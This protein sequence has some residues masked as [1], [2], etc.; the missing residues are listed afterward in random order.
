MSAGTAASIQN[1]RV[2]MKKE[3]IFGVQPLPTAS[4]GT[5]VGATTNAAG[6]AVG[7][8][9]ITLASDGTGTILT[10]D[11]ITIA[12]DTNYY[13]VDNGDSDVSNGGTIVLKTGLKKAIAASAKAI[14]IATVDRQGAI[15][16]VFA[17]GGA[18]FTNKQGIIESNEIKP[19]RMTANFDRETRKFTSDIKG[20]LQ[21][22]MYDHLLASTLGRDFADNLISENPI[23]ADD[24]TS[25]ASVTNIDMNKDITALH[26][27]VGD[28]IL[29]ISTTSTANA[30]IVNKKFVVQ[31]FTAATGLLT[32]RPHSDNYATAKIIADTAK[33]IRIKNLTN[34]ILEYAGN[35]NFIEMPAAFVSATVD[36]TDY[37]TV[38]DI[39]IASGTG[40]A[41]NRN[42]Q[43]IITE[44]AGVS[45]RS[46]FG[47]FINNSV[48]LV[49]NGTTS[50]GGATESIVLTRN[51]L[52]RTDATATN[53]LAI[54]VS[55]STYKITSTANSLVADG[56][57]VGT[58]F[59]CFGAGFLTAA[60]KGR[61]FKV[62]AMAAN[63]SNLTFIPMDNG[64]APVAETGIDGDPTGYIQ[65]YGGTTYIPQEN[66]T[67][68]SWS[69]EEFYSD[70]TQ[71]VLNYGQKVAGF[72]ITTA[73]NGIP[74][75]SFTLMGKGANNPSA[76]EFY[77]SATFPLT[78]TSLSTIYSK[79]FYSGV[80]IGCITKFD[81]NVVNGI[82]MSERC[83]GSDTAQHSFDGKVKVSGTVGLLFTNNEAKLLYLNKEEQSL[84]L[85]LGE[86]AEPT[87]DFL[88]FTMPRV[89]FTEADNANNMTGCEITMPFTAFENPNGNDGAETP[90]IMSAL[91]I[92]SSKA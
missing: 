12:G 28:T 6:Y 46:I 80:Q 77:T 33:G 66:H 84:D 9:T 3:R 34:N 57:K 22:G 56:F 15:E 32:L 26:L 60:N 11:T 91:R 81:L 16:V 76:S 40:V 31:A 55:G 70:I 62:I 36:W 10:G 67:T 88:S 38:G 30:G 78:S 71:S 58:V 7:T 24:I 21:A 25:N 85:Y 63:G 39:V 54:T 20:D 43:F 68:D 65:Q 72:S 29:V 82:T 27:A 74:Q 41:G 83:Y 86:S 69:I 73:N 5:A 64:D 17:D 13:E 2:R 87:A 50:A 59:R 35:T 37:F 49:D 44:I 18:N 53:L 19:S 1:K 8:K 14:T 45:N 47:Y 4:K 42:K 89:V 61:N 79:L 48:V 92:Q 90:F 51:G 23:V 75:I 52:V